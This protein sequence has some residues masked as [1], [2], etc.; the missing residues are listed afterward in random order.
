MQQRLR[1]NRELIPKFI[2]ETL[3]TEGPIKGAFRLVR[4]ST[5]LGGVELP[6]GTQVML[7]NAAAKSGTPASSSARR[8]SGWNGPTCAVTWPSGTACT[9]ARGRRWPA[10]RCV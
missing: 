9:P 4:K 2:E 10:P 8:S 3:R 5:T 7:L 6:A 1:Q